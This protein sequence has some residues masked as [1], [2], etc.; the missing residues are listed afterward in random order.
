MEI[1]FGGAGEAGVDE[2]AQ[3]GSSDEESASE[4]GDARPFSFRW[5]VGDPKARKYF[6]G[7]GEGAFNWL[8]GE[9]K[10]QVLAGACLPPLRVCLR[11]ARLVSLCAL[12]LLAN[13]T[14]C[15]VEDMFCI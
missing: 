2:D 13:V 12:P 5:F 6:C 3:G 1:G 15:C 9:L 10:L 4:D 14:L 11:C 7:L 8:W